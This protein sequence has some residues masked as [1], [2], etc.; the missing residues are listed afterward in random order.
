MIYG[1]VSDENV[2]EWQR[3]Y[4]QFKDKLCMNRKTGKEVLDYLSSKYILDETT[5]EKYIN[6]VSET[7][8]ENE[9]FNQKLPENMQPEPKAFILRNEGNGKIIYENQEDVFEGCPVFIG[10]D[11]SSGYVQVEGS[12]LL[13]DGIYAFQGIDKYD[14]ENYVRIADYIECIKRFNLQLYN[15]ICA[16]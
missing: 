14:L 3:M 12:F 7:V 16:D 10:I 11:M 4:N 13:Y 9:F 5:D 15:R 8:L 2:R 1:P 6:V